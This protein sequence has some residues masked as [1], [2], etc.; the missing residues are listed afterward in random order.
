[1]RAYCCDRSRPLRP[2][3]RQRPVKRIHAFC[4]RVLIPV[5][6]CRCPASLVSRRCSPFTFASHSTCRRSLPPVRARACFARAD[7]ERGGAE[8]GDASRLGSKLRSRRIQLLARAWP[9]LHAPHCTC[10]FPLHFPLFILLL[11]CPSSCPP[12]MLS[13]PPSPRVQRRRSSR[14]LR[15]RST[16]RTNR[17]VALPRTPSAPPRR[18][19]P[20]PR[21]PPCTASKSTRTS[22]TGDE[23]SAA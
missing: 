22:R 13:S 21:S 12:L 8:F 1:M 23:R 15:A 4:A 14:P 18:R 2:R 17:R 20:P 5:R 16:R 3:E 19:R 11:S 9:L 10:F 7:V 6:L